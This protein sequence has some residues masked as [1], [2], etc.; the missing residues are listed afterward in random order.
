M[1]LINFKMFTILYERYA[2][3]GKARHEE[4]YF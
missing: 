1:D 2:M 4:K 3:R